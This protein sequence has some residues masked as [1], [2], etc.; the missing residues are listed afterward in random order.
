MGSSQSQ[1]SSSSHAPAQAS[2]SPAPIPA[3][4]P[5]PPSSS[6]LNPNPTSTAQGILSYFFNPSK[7]GV[8]HD[9]LHPSALEVRLV[10]KYL[11]HLDL[12]A[13]LVPRVLDHAE[14]WTSCRRMNNKHVLVN[15]L[16]H[17]GHL[18]G[19]E[20]PWSAGQADEVPHRARVE[21]DG[22][23]RCTRGN[24]WYLVSSPIGCTSPPRPGPEPEPEPRL[25]H[26][27]RTQPEAR[28]ATTSTHASKSGAQSQGDQRDW[29]EVW[30]RRCVVET[31]SRDQMWST[32]SAEHY[33]TYEQ[34][35]SWF[36]ISL[37]RGTK[38]VEGSRHA[39]QHN[40]VAG[41][42]YKSHINTLEHDHPTL[43]LAQPGDRIVLWV[44]AQYQGWQNWVKEAALT[45]YT[46][47]Y[48]PSS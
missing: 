7:P 30:I 29:D 13:E 8:T 35:H 11:I 23:L 43:K 42:Y 44:R 28:P 20:G 1:E 37:L 41:Q 5:P 47:P 36:E 21:S 9:H 25:G 17:R 48:P 24:V 19:G 15:S 4:D 31:L 45:I 32:S 2:P 6:P 34:S 26:Q 3:P 10:S 18:P 40:V 46:S 39:I 22:G 14:Y 27:V 16:S 12:P 38:E 33:G